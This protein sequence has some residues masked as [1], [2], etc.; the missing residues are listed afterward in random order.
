MT[1]RIDEFEW[2]EVLV[3]KI[4]VKHGVEP[5]AVESAL[6]NSDPSPITR[7]AEKGKY[8]CW[9]QVDEDGCYLFIVFSMPKPYTVR[10][11]SARLMTPREKASYR[12]WIAG[13]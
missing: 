9:A 1:L 11:I 6:L 8:R 3:E 12:N 7:K 13:R 10:V 4:A 5:E 2:T